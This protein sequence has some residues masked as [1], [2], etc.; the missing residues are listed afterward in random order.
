MALV[1]KIHRYVEQL[2]ERLQVEVLEFVEYLHGKTQRE[3]LD[4]EQKEWAV[5]SL[6]NTMK[7]MEDEELPE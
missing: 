6:D 3:Q 5:F 1:D 2:P 7:G 4:T